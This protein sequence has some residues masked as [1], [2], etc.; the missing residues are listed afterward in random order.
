MKVTILKEAG[1]EEA[2]LGLSLSFNRPWSE[3]VELSVQ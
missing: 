2:L 1:Y 3:M